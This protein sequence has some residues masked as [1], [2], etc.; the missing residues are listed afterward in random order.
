MNLFNYGEFN[1][2]SGTKSNFKIDCDALTD[3]DIDSI[4]Q[5]VSDAIYF[6]EIQFRSI[7]SIPTGGDRFA[8]ALSKYLTVDEENDMLPVL[9]VDDVF[10]TGKTINKYRQKYEYTE[11]LVLF[12]RGDH[13]AEQVEA[14]FSLDPGFHERQK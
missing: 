3:E 2:S 4:A 8:K 7:V 11:T 13:I 12:S 6:N 10:T 1:L 5:L 9:L 14:V